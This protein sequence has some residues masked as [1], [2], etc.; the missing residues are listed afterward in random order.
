[1]LKM[2]FCTLL[3]LGTV[4]MAFAQPKVGDACTTT[5]Q[6]NLQQADPTLPQPMPTLV[7]N[8]ATKKCEAIIEQKMPTPQT[9]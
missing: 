5:Q 9:N 7:C 4:S 2:T 8:A 3:L 1:M 6:C